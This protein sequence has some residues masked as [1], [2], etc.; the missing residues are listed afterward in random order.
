MTTKIPVGII[1][2]TGTVG[3]RLATLLADHPWFRLTSVAASP[4]SAGKPYARAVRGRWAVAAPIPP[5]AGKLVVKRVEDDVETVAAEVA[6]AFS[7]VSL[8]AGRVRRLEEA[9]AARG[10]AVVSNNSA[11][12][13]TDDVPVILPEINAE[14]VA[15]V[16]AQRRRRGWRQG[17]IAAKP[18][19]SVQSYLPV[20]KA[21]E[22]FGPRRVSV[23]TLQA[24]SGAGRTL[25]AWPEMEDNVI[26]FIPGEEEKSEREPLKILGTVENGRLRLA[27]V[28]IF[29]ATCLRVPISDG[30][31]AS[32]T[33]ELEEP[34]SRAEVVAA[35]ANYANPI[36]ALRLPSAPS[37]FLHVREEDDRPQTRLDRDLAGGM[38]VSVGRLRPDGGP[39]RWKF[40]ALSHNTLRGAAG[41][42]VLLAELLLARGYVR[43]RPPL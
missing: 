16:D 10:V 14:H 28:P 36:A 15:L 22:G 6:I 23:T 21:L 37:Q 12:R 32:A 38:A 43:P 42:A 11:H 13:W 3:Q 24:V 33:V 8:E 40:V 19:C 18:N 25:A 41:G 34:A 20:V 17:L 29:S 2:A 27:S 5:A 30:H 4:E 26:P 1:G 31:M 39:T 35:L 9:Y 7:A